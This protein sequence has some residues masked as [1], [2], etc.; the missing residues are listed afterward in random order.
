V[1]G[2]VAVP[3]YPG[4]TRLRGRSDAFSDPRRSRVRRAGSLFPHARSLRCRSPCLR[5]CD[6]IRV[7]CETLTPCAC[8]LSTSRTCLSLHVGCGPLPWHHAVTLVARS[9][10][11]CRNILQAISAELKKLW[12]SEPSAPSVSPRFSCEAWDQIICKVGPASLA[13]ALSMVR[14]HSLSPRTL[15]D[16][17]RCLD[18]PKTL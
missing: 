1:R 13:V 18:H 11:D 17:L 6:C 14:H 7:A 16:R 10:K 5:V 8:A 9:G 4:R 3:Q 2:R 12:P 15:H